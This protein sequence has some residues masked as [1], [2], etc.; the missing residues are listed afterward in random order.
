MPCGDGRA[1]DIGDGRGDG[2]DV[3]A[4]GEIVAANRG[5][6]GES[7][8]GRVE[9]KNVE[10]GR[11]SGAMGHRALPSER[12]QWGIRGA[13]DDDYY[14]AFGMGWVFPFRS[15]RLSGVIVYSQ[16]GL[17]VSSYDESFVSLPVSVALVP[18]EGAFTVEQTASNPCIF[19]WWNGGCAGHGGS[20]ARYYPHGKKLSAL[21]PKLLMYGYGSEDKQDITL[22]IDGFSSNSVARVARFHAASPASPTTRRPCCVPSSEASPRRMTAWSSI[23]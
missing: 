4:A 8:D 17:A 10:S 14:Q 20:G 22:G 15:N 9:V 7:V 6:D 1:G 21:I 16:G 18:R 11:E 2:C 23:R 3:L 12:S 19:A 5:V 13:W